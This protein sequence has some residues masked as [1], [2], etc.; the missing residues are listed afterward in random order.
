VIVKVSRAAQLC[1]RNYLGPALLH[2]ALAIGF[3]SKNFTGSQR[4]TKSVPPPQVCIQHQGGRIIAVEEETPA[5]LSAGVVIENHAGPDSEAISYSVGCLR[6]DQNEL[7]GCRWVS[8]A[9]I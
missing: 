3:Q 4:E 9:A 6:K 2:W 7:A 8:A 5:G 1:V